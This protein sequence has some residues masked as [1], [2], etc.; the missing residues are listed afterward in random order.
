[1]RA[2]L[3]S[4]DGTFSVEE[5]DTPELPDRDWVRVRVRAAGVC[6]TDLRH[7]KVADPALDGHVVGHEVAGEVDQVG[8]DFTDL[9][10]GDRVVVE[11]VM[12]DGVCPWC[13][14]RRYN[15]CPH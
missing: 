5:V 15:I 12:G 14:I 11:T 4:A 7:W 8:P 1:M 13:R 9:K 3:K 2:A 10:P 6:G